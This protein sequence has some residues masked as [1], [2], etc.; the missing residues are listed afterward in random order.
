MNQPLERT[1]RSLVS[2]VLLATCIV[3]GSVFGL[4]RAFSVA[5]PQ[6]PCPDSSDVESTCEDHVERAFADINCDGRVDAEDFLLLLSD[7]GGNGSRAADVNFDGEV[8]LE[9][10][11]ALV[12]QLGE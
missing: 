5:E 9:D 4:T 1:G 6:Q 2:I 10:F 12:R 11:S 8:D 7:F 3:T